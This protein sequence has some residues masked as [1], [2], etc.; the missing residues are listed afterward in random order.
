M[1]CLA[2]CGLGNIGE[3]FPDT[4]NR[5]KGVIELEVS[6]ANGRIHPKKRI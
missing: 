3:M 2:L 1:H 5:Y 6:S 4:D